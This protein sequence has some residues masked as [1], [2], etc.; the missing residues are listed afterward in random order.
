MLLA[1]K[2]VHDLET[3]V[4]G[5]VVVSVPS[6]GVGHCP[7]VRLV[8]SDELHHDLVSVDDG[9][10]HRSQLLVANLDVNL[11]PLKTAKVTEQ[12]LIVAYDC[13][14]E[15]KLQVSQIRAEFFEQLGIL[16]K[17]LPF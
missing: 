11:F 3:V 7:V 1:A 5:A 16:P 4:H 10:S 13:F 12:L 17:L 15:L 2:H 6:G 14:Q 8:R 9:E